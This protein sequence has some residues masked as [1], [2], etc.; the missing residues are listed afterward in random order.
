MTGVGGRWVRGGGVLGDHKVTLTQNL[1]TNFTLLDFFKLALMGERRGR[2]GE[3]GRKGR[4][5]RRK[6]RRGHNIF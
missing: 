6:G 4:G 3:V 5:G 2:E 1:Q